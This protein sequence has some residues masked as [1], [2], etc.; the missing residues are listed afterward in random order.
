VNNLAAFD[1]IVCRNVMIYFG[2]DLMK[3]MIQQFRECL[4]PEGWLLVGP[5]E[6]NMTCFTSFRAV[7]AH[8]VTLYQK[9]RDSTPDSVEKV[10]AVPALAPP[11]P[12]QDMTFSQP[13]EPLSTKIG[14]TLVTCATTQIVASGRMPPGAVTGCWKKRT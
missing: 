13:V 14:P 5:S 1:L 12:M 6:P 4:V 7:S 3:R 8:D 11:P 10:F 2:P 9:P